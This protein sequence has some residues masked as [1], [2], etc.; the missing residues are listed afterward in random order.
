MVLQGQLEAQALDSKLR[1]SIAQGTTRQSSWAWQDR[2]YPSTEC[3]YARET[4]PVVNVLESTSVSPTGSPRSTKRRLP[5]PRITGW[6]MSLS[7]SSSPSSSSD[8]TRAPLPMIVI[9]LPGLRFSPAT[10]SATS[11]S[12]RDELFHP[13]G[14]SKV[15]ETTN[16]GTLF[17]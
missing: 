16:L 17:M 4:T 8:R 1:Q 2:H 10:P 11:P 14:S 7:S 15:L 9:S 13:R 6:T 3:R 5:L 12:T